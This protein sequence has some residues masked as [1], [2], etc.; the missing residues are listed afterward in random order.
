M[1]ENAELRRKQRG[2][3]EKMV[4]VC[5]VGCGFMGRMHANVYALLPGAELVG[6]ID[7][8]EA[9]GRAFANERKAAFFPGLA[10]AIAGV[11]FDVVDICL[12]THLHRDFTL[13]AARAGKHVFCEKPMARTLKQADEMIAACRDAGVRLMI[14]HCIRFWPEYALLEEMAN[15][16]RYG[17]LLSVN[18]TRY[19]EFPTWSSENWLADETKAGG[20]ALDMHIHDTDFALHLL[21]EPSEIRSWGTDDGRGIGQIFTT[22][23]FPGGTVAHLEGGWNLPPQTPFKMAFRAIFEHAAAIMDGAPMKVY[24]SSGE[25]FQPEFPQMK[26]EGGGNISDL[27]GYYHELAYFVDCLKTGRPM[28]RCTPEG[29]RGSLE[30]CL[31]EIRQAEQGAVRGRRALGGRKRASC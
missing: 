6:V 5:L 17:K 8:D 31:E 9:R 3:F 12:P 24:P 25:P 30:V 4:K 22:M 13:Q 23:A 26:A 29:A 18:L 21:G 14:G 11:A 19:G 2:S 16:G 27:G 28:D 15:D 7:H 1:A 20:G 10:E